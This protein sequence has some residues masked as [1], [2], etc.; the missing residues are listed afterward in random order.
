MGFLQ[1]TPSRDMDFTKKSEMTRLDRMRDCSGAVSSSCALS[2]DSVENSMD[3]SKK[4]SSIEGNCMVD[5]L[6]QGRLDLNMALERKSAR[7]TFAADEVEH[8]QAEAD[9]EEVKDVSMDKKKVQSLW[10]SLKRRMKRKQDADK[11][12]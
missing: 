11:S 9:I 1:F 10:K 8:R 12:N 7:V 4:E 6:D 3:W 2:V 5:E